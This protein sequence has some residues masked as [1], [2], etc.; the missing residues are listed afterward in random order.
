MIDM[1]IAATNTTPTA[2]FW[3]IR[4]S[5]TPSLGDASSGSRLQGPSGCGNFRCH[6]PGRNRGLVAAGW[7]TAAMCTVLSSGQQ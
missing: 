1:N 7:R 4:G 5:T 3:L 6:R 2:T